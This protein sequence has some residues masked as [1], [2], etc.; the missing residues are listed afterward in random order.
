MSKGQ[1]CRS[2]VFVIA[3]LA[4]TACSADENALCA[5][6]ALSTGCP[7][8]LSCVGGRCVSDAERCGVEIGVVTVADPREGARLM[9]PVSVVASATEAFSINQ[10]QVWDD[11]SKLGWYPGSSIR[12]SYV[13]SSG[14]H[15]L[16]IEDMDDS[17][18]V[19]HQTVVHCTVTSGKG[20]AIASPGDGAEV[21]SPVRVVATA[22][23]A[24]AISQIQVWE[25]ANKLGWYVGSSIDESYALAP[26]PHTLTV[27]DM[28]EAF[29]V[30]DRT[31][32]T[33]TVR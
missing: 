11:G 10:L 13:L 24:V 7:F 5:A 25:G 30:I 14:A 16:T 3:A 12:E 23:A 26:G 17:F 20:V 31:L 21:D 28:N 9:N 19:I 18:T 15:T 29:A 4:F 22:S 33:F 27:E 2:G 8:G 32:V 6:C 1:Q